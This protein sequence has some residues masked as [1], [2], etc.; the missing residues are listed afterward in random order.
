MYI[1][2]IFINLFIYLFIYLLID[3]LV[4]WWI[5]LCRYECRIETR[6][7][8]WKRSNGGWWKRKG[9]VSHEIG[10]RKN[11]TEEERAI[12]GKKVCRD[13]SYRRWSRAGRNTAARC[14]SCAAGPEAP[15]AWR[16]CRISCRPMRWRNEGSWRYATWISAPTTARWPGSTWAFRCSGRVRLPLPA[17]RNLIRRCAGGRWRAAWC[18]T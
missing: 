9:K 6:T 3:W 18:G 2:Y 13:R 1:S 5:D 7:N 17:S 11:V 10:R 16:V 15:D 12:E 14:H 8:D 4:G